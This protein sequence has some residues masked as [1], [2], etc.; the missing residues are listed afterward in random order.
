MLVLSRKPHET[1]RIGNDVC[2]TVISIEG[3]V[4]KLGIVAP[5][6]VPVHRGEVYERIQEENRLAAQS[7]PGAL[8]AH[9]LAQYWNSVKKARTP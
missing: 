6:L 2:I 9:L 4:V 3:G 7:L 8:P 1:V 5:H